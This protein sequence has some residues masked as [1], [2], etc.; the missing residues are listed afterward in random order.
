MNSANTREPAVENQRI[1]LLLE[2][3][4]YLALPRP[5]QPSPLLLTGP[6]HHP[7]STLDA[8]SSNPR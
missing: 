5:T 3:P 2:R 4:A 6:R 7:A 8:G 1:P